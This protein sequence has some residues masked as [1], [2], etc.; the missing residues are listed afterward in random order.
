MSI[1]P[2]CSK[3]EFAEIQGYDDWDAFALKHKDYPKAAAMDRILARA[4]QKINLTIG[5]RDASTNITDE[6][7]TTFLLDLCYRMANLM[8]DDEQARSD[9]K[10][11]SQFIPR[12]YLF[13]KDRDELQL[14]GIEKGYRDVGGVG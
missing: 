2:Y 12:D 3:D 10:P 6:A 4:T 7:W 9:S 5:I 14:L 1:T 13:Q 11:R 8:I